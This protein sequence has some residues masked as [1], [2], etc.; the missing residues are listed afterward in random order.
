[1]T[2][3]YYWRYADQKIGKYSKIGPKIQCSLYLSRSNFL[4][5]NVI[6]LLAVTSLSE[7]TQFGLI[8]ICVIGYKIINPQRYP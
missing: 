6:A 7:K 3:L 5:N 1:M 8:R 4:V 2:S